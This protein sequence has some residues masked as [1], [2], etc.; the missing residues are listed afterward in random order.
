V[1]LNNPAIRPQN[2]KDKCD[3]EPTGSQDEVSAQPAAKRGLFLLLFPMNSSAVLG[4]GS[5]ELMFAEI[6]SEP[7][8]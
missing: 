3:M 2:I 1:T 4:Q 7:W 6:K 5:L 8:R